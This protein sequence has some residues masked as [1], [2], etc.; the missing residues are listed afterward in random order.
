[1][2]VSLVPC[3]RRV[4]FR[5]A[6]CELRIRGESPRSTRNVFW[7]HGS[8]RAAAEKRATK[9]NRGHAGT[10]E[11]LNKCISSRRRYTR[12]RKLSSW[13]SQCSEQHG[14]FPLG[15]RGRSDSRSKRKESNNN[16][17]DDIRLHLE[18]HISLLGIVNE[19]RLI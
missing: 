10:E 17:M 11:A 6:E 7:L 18:N 14:I 4:W 9:P 12:R 15:Y 13:A 16:H 3:I 1:M 19:C 8:P 2:H 5:G